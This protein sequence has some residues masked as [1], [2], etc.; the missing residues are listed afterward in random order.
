MAEPKREPWDIP[1]GL[2]V[3]IILLIG[4]LV[5]WRTRGPVFPASAVPAGATPS[6]TMQGA[7]T[8]APPT[9]SPVNAH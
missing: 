8:V 5:L 2:F 3:V 9:S 1:A 6:D 4:G 7:G